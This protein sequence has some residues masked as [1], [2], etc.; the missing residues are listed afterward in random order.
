MKRPQLVPT[1]SLNRILKSAE[2]AWS[3]RDF[4]KAIDELERANRLAPGNYQIALQLGRVYGLRYDYA[5]A[6][7][8]FEKAIRLAPQKTEALCAAAQNAVDFPDHQLAERYFQIALKQKDA[9]AETFTRLAELY[10]RLH[11]TDE[12]AELVN[13]A[14][15]LE[16]HCAV[17]RLARARFDKQA[18]RFADAEKAIQSVLSANNR[19]TRIRGYYELGM[20]LDRAGRYDD[21]M[22]AFHEAKSLLQSEAPHLLAQ[23]QAVR[24]YWMEMQATI[25]GEIFQRWFNTSSTLS[26]VRRI[27]FLGG[28]PRSGTTLLEQILDSHPGLVSAEETTLFND[29]VYVP[30]VRNCPPGTAMLPMLESASTSLLRQLR[31][32]YFSV[33]TKHIGSPIGERL[34][35]DKNP[36]INMLIPAFMRVFPEIKLLIALRDPRD[37]CLSC[38][39]QAHLPL[40]KGS[41]AFLT[42]EGTVD[43]YTRVMGLWRT[44]A[45]MIEGH[46]LQVRYEDMVQDLESVAR[47]VLK[48]LDVPWDERVLRFNEYAQKKIVRSPTYADVAKPIF[49]R[50]MG[51]WHKYEKYF[52]P[53]LAKLEP[54]LKAFG[55][56]M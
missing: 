33:L 14:L 20:I 24:A 52:E 12:A 50:A 16:P 3:N 40:T 44:L 8:C 27:A 34:L 7:R 2:D 46:Y 55:Y 42:L 18:G 13:R 35:I 37:V 26:P 32:N 41:V 25:S 38:F 10:E 29:D 17:A 9:S 28:Y 43:A 39:M 30:L 51:R 31:E 56:E 1:G 19:D 36:A 47:R 22:A 23:L 15:K 4:Q 48:F 5:S 45:P 6:E 54:F 11:R 21:A 53:H 49:T